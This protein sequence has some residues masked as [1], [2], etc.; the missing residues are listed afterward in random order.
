MKRGHNRV[1]N[2]KLDYI[3]I[4]IHFKTDQFTKVPEVLK[5]VSK[6]ADSWRQHPQDIEDKPKRVW[7]P[8]EQGAH[9]LLVIC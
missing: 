4:Y 7:G 3:Y 2:T 5:A 9:V 1:K 8:A 6:G